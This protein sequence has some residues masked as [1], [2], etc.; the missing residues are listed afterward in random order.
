MH[1]KA[2][3]IQPVL[4]TTKVG[5]QPPRGKLRS[6]NGAFRGEVHSRVCMQRLLTVIQPLIF[7][8]IKHPLVVKTFDLFFYQPHILVVNLSIGM[9][10]VQMF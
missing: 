4:F 1:Q 6:G 9:K 3:I 10:K 2:K 8:P 5:G 7:E